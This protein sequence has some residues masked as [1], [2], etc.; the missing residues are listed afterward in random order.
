M[1]Q[2]DVNG[3]G[4]LPL[5]FLFVD[6][7]SECT[8]IYY[9]G[10]ADWVW[11]GNHGEVYTSINQRGSDVDLR[12]IWLPA[13]QTSSGEG[14]GVISRDQINFGKI[15]QHDEFTTYP[16]YTARGLDYS[17]TG[18]WTN[19]C[20]ACTIEYENKGCPPSCNQDDLYYPLE[21]IRNNGGGGARVKAD[22][23]Q[24]C[25][26]RGAGSGLSPK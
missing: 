15:F 19:L 23:A 24:Y 12:P 22:G 21:L 8:L 2:V 14:S 10:R 13:K 1:A 6:L 20:K 18:N 11:V 5:P 3:D 17:I 26:M 9:I 16:N 7:R 25:D 4:I